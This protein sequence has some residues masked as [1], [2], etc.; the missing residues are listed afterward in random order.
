VVRHGVPVSSSVGGSRTGHQRTT[1]LNRHTPLSRDQIEPA[2]V[3]IIGVIAGGRFGYVLFTAT[4]NSPT[5]RCRSFASGTA[6][7]HVSASAR[8]FASL[9]NSLFAS[10]RR[11][12]DVASIRNAHRDTR[13]VL[14]PDCE[15]HQRRALGPRHAVGDQNVDGN[16]II[17][18]ALRP[19]ANGL[20]R[21]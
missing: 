7:Y 10:L 12:N 2:H 18:P 9:V 20:S 3:V 4:G 21:R 1:A 11:P 15:L 17:A 6:A 8:C 5:T 16:V 19:S 14:V 13:R